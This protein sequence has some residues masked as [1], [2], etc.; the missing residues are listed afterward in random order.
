MTFPGGVPLHTSAGPVGGIGV[1]GGSPEQD[2][3]IARTGAA[4]L[5]A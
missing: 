1:S 4:A 5:T 3:Q 2:A